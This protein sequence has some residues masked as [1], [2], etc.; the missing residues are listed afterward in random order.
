[1]VALGERGAAAGHL[2]GLGDSPS[3]GRVHRARR[4]SPPP[5]TSSASPPHAPGTAPTTRRSP[6]R[7]RPRGPGPPRAA[8]RAVLHQ[9][10]ARPRALRPRARGRSR[11]SPSAG[12]P[13]RVGW[14]ADPRLGMTGIFLSLSRV[15]PDATRSTTTWSGTSTPSTASATCSTSAIIVPRL[16][17]ALRL[18]GRRARAS[19]APGSPLR[20]RT[21]RRRTRGTRRTPPSG[22]PRRRV[23]R[24]R[25]GARFRRHAELWCT[26]VHRSSLASGHDP[27]TGAARRALAALR[28]GRRARR[29][30]R[31]RHPRRLGR[32]RQG[33]S[34]RVSGRTRPSVPDLLHRGIATAVYGGL[35]VGLRAAS[36]G[37]DRAA[38]TGAGPRLEADA[39]GRFVELGGQRADRRPAGR[40]SGRGWRSRWRCAPTAATYP[41]TA[42][43]P[44]RRVPR[45]HRPGGRLPARALRE[46]VV[47]EPAPRRSRHDVRRDAGRRGLDAGLPARQHRARPARERRRALRA[48]AAAGRGVA[49]RRSTRVAL[50]GHSMGGLIIRAAGAVAHRRRPSRWTDLVSDVVTLG[51][52][53]LGAPIARGIGHGSRGLARL[54][55]TAAFGRILDWRS[56]GVHD[57]VA[58]LAEDV[59]PLP[60][61][62]YRLVAATA[63]RRRSGTRSATSSATCWCG[64]RRRTAGTGTAPS[65]SRARTC[66]TSAAPTTSACSTTPR[67]TARC[68][69]GWPEP[70]QSSSTRQGSGWSALL[71]KPPRFHAG[72]IGLHPAG[73]VVGAHAQAVLARAGA[74]H[75]HVNRLPRPAPQAA[76]GSSVGV[77][78]G[79]AAVRA[80][81]DRASTGAPARPGPALEH[82]RPGPHHAGAGHEVREARRHQQRPR[83]DPGHRLARRRP[84]PA[85][86]GRRWLLEALE[87]LGLHA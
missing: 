17:S 12:W 84:G 30:D 79:R 8:R 32:P 39:R 85:G 71:A 76:L 42:D 45:R 54:P 40:A 27:G 10:R 25:P 51:T 70:G 6:R 22:T 34:R 5:S 3:A 28:G 75:S 74:S 67:S 57:L 33:I 44:G 87:R 68:G 77:R 46:R 4:A 69:T 13:P 52:P 50:V 66:C 47:L 2:R 53:H 65:C 72:S 16:G 80:H 43:G 19:G 11:G 86:A 18:V 20:P 82:H 58:G 59:P 83:L 38:A 24:G 61:A 63:D 9:P 60:H 55:E 31:A 73:L 26:P 62:R 48:D 29:A 14:L 1:M 56:V 15:L 81:L 36:K 64:C 41:S 49:G 37:L 35:S 23:S 21:R 7:P 78:P